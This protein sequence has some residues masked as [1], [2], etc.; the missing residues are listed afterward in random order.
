MVRYVTSGE[1]T[2]DY[3]VPE[4]GQLIAGSSGG[5]SLYSAIGARQWGVEVGIHS[6]VGR[7]Y[8]DHFFT[9]LGAAGL[10]MDGVTRGSD[11]N[12]LSL[13]LLF[14]EENRKQQL[15]RLRSGT[16]EQLGQIR[17]PLPGAYLTARGF[18]LAPT[19]PETHLQVKE[20]IRRQAPNAIITMDLWVE[21]FFDVD[22]YRRDDLVH[23]LTA[24]LPSR[25]EVEQLWGEPP[26]LVMQR[27]CSAGLACMAVKMDEEGSLVY[28]PRTQ[29]LFHVPIFTTTVA[30]TTGA[31]D[32]YCGGFLVGLGETGDPVEAALRGTVSASFAV[33]DYGALSSLKGSQGEAQRRL[34]QLRPRVRRLG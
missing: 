6:S 20:L 29:G 26:D 1:L 28:D 2:I 30:D 5:G 17:R 3:V 11:C 34:E 22:P 32:A 4:H 10:R 23:G 12:S 21:P 19:L 18:H 25:K 8:P 31:G 33:E 7:D 15:P 13:W 16:L 14:E 27:L 9:T 24:L